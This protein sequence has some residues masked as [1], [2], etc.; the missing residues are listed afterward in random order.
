MCKRNDPFISLWPLWIL[1]TADLI[2]PWLRPLWASI[3][4]QVL[5]NK[6]LHLP[7]HAELRQLQESWIRA[8]RR[9]FVHRLRM[10][11]P[12]CIYFLFRKAEAIYEKEEEVQMRRCKFCQ[13]KLKHVSAQSHACMSMHLTTQISSLQ[14]LTATPSVGVWWLWRSWSH[15]RQ[16]SDL[17]L[18]VLTSAVDFRTQLYDQR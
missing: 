18:G 17:W 13:V 9:L 2:C 4:G 15:S 12:Q 10:F 8:P 16:L 3:L 5:P 6:P 7:R 14:L 11:S 1:Q